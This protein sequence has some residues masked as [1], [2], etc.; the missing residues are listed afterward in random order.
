MLSGK[1]KEA[2]ISMGTNT[3]NVFKYFYQPI[4]LEQNIVASQYVRH[5][6]EV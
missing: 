6:F 5:L 1:L 2:N 4:F 3:V